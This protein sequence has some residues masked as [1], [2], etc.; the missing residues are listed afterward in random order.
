MLGQDSFIVVCNS[1][2]GNVSD[3]VNVSFAR[4]SLCCR[5]DISIDARWSHECLADSA[6]QRSDMIGNFQTGMLKHDFANE[7]VAI[8]MKAV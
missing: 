5:D 4:S 8:G 6:V 3:R 1:A 2:T 7:A